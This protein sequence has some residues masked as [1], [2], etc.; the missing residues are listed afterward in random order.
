M[1]LATQ[2]SAGDGHRAAEWP[3][4]ARSRAGYARFV[5]RAGEPELG[6]R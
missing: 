5:K 2:N 4:A 3:F 1:R 6:G